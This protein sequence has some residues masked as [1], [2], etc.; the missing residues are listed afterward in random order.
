MKYPGISNR[1]IKTG[2]AILE[3]LTSDT[4]LCF[5]ENK[6]QQLLTRAKQVI[7]SN[8]GF[9]IYTSSTSQERKPNCRRRRWNR[10][11]C[12]PHHLSPLE[13]ESCFFTQMKQDK[14]I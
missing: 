9:L 5:P 3:V 2:K 8:L 7:I 11:R 6:S 14:L 10:S 13:E 12:P 4:H 1:N